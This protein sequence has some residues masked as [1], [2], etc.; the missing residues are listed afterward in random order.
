MF[1]PF[2]LMIKKEKHREQFCL[3]NYLKNAK[4]TFV[5]DVISNKKTWLVL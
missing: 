1:E 3:C 4:F 5:N 2:G